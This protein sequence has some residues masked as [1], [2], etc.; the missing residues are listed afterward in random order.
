M[1]TEYVVGFL[2]NDYEVVLIEKNRPQWQAGKLNGVGGHIEKYDATPYSAML[3]EFWEETGVAIEGWE[4]FLTLEGKYSEINVFALYSEELPEV[5]TCTDEKI[6][7]VPFVDIGDNDTVSNLKW[8]LPLMK[9]RSEY[10]PIHVNF[11]GDE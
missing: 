7:V 11:Y 4:Q 10:K 2:Y 5:K 8:I 1:K 6:R 9:Q 3:R